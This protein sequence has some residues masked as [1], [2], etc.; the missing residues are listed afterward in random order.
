[1]QEPLELYQLEDCTTNLIDSKLYAKIK[2]TSPSIALCMGECLVLDK[3][4]KEQEAE[5]KNFLKEMHTEL[6]IVEVS[7]N[8]TNWDELN[9]LIK[10]TI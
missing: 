1:M 5:V 7:I 8:L 2:H 4:L 10:G 6:R 3:S 9:L